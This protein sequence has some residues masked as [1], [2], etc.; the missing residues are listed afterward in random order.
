MRASAHPAAGPVSGVRL[1]QWMV[2]PV[3]TRLETWRV[4][5]IART[6]WRTVH[7][8]HLTKSIRRSHTCV[9][10]VSPGQASASLAQRHG[11]LP[12][13]IG[14]PVGLRLASSATQVVRE[15][16]EAKVWPK[17]KAGE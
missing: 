5:A 15:C 4:A 14:L 2:L 16:D 8:T 17:R 10:N 1:E 13:R 12:V 9:A 7:M 11:L 6:G 3:G